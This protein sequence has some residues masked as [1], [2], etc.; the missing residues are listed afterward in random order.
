MRALVVLCLIANVARAEPSDRTLVLVGL[1]LAPP[2]YLLGVGLH[3]GSH[4]IAAKIVGA[5]VDDVHLFPPGRDPRSGHFR[6]GWTYVRGLKTKGDRIFFYLAP[7]ITGAILLG[8]YGALVLTDGWPSNKYGQLAL[9]VLAT[10]WWVDFA[11]DVLL[12]HPGNDVVKAFNLWCMKGWRQVPA[13]LVYAAANA[14]F[15]YLVYRGYRRTFDDDAP[16]NASSAL[17]LP[18]LSAAF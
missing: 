16:A 9:T 8:G 2:T 13:R 10:G 1:G 3:E 15:G 18:V 7:K 5:T 6:F 11:K 12:F 4:A 14:G 17:V